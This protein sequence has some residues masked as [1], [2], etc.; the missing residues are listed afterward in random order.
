M[1]YVLWL[2]MS[3]LIKWGAAVHSDHGCNPSHEPQLHQN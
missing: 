1:G 2:H 3:Q